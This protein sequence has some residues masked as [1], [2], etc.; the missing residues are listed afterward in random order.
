MD[1]WLL[2]TLQANPGMLEMFRVRDRHCEPDGNRRNGSSLTSIHTRLK[3]MRWGWQHC[4]NTCAAPTLRY[5]A[6]AR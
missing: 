1:N 5:G 6:M 4:H 2:R 3:L